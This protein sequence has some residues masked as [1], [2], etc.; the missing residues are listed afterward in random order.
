VIQREIPVIPANVLLGENAAIFGK[1]SFRRFFGRLDPA[2][3]IG[4]H[5]TA[6]E[7]QFAVG[8]NGTIEI[9]EHCYLADVILLC[10]LHLTIGNYVMIGWHVTIADSDFHPI[11]PAERIV[12]AVA[13]SPL[14]QGLARPPVPCKAV[15][16]EDDVWI[17]PKAAV[18]KGVRIG[19]G[20]IVEPGAVVTRDIPPRSRVAGNPAHVVGEL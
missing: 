8:R 3:R 9:G 4:S 7:V 15:A 10:E 2:V 6:D 11:A 16:I 17:G 19:A 20:S 12:D 18:M 5:S 13:C 1:D 14:H